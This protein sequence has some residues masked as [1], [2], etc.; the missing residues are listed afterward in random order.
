[1]RGPSW[2]QLTRPAKFT[3]NRIPPSSSDTSTPVMWSQDPPSPARSVN[4][5]E[6]AAPPKPVRQRATSAL[7]RAKGWDFRRI[8]PPEGWGWG[9]G[10]HEVDFFLDRSLLGLAPDAGFNLVVATTARNPDTAPNVGT[11]DYEPVPG[12]PSPQ[13]RPD[14]RPPH[15]TAFPATATRGRT[16]KL[17]YWALDGRDRTREV[18][19]IFRGERLLRTIRTPLRDTNPFRMSQLDWK[20]QQGVRG[21]LRSRSARSTPPATRETAPGQR[22]P[23]ASSRLR[24]TA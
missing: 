7:Y 10:P 22:S 18:V 17:G 15:I 1:M 21:K 16:A 19:H 24:P 2:P 13:L 6:V 3:W 14:R 12:T 11:F 23:S 9:L 20:V 8:T 5:V 4:V